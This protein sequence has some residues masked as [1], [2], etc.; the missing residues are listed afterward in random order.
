[1]KGKRPTA[2]GQG[3]LSKFGSGREEDKLQ[4]PQDAEDRPAFPLHT[5]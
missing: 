2:R 4:L 5:K 1:M 3:A